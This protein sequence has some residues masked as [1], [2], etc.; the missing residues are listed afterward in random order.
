[1]I[2]KQKTTV[3]PKAK[4]KAKRQRP[5]RVGFDFD[6]VVIYNP[7]RILR[8]FASFIKKKNLVK[9]KELEFFIPEKNWEKFLWWLAHQSSLFPAK[10]WSQVKHLKQQGKIEPYLI[11]GR[12]TFLKS[13]LE[14]KFRLF[15]LDNIFNSVHITENNEQPHIFKERIIKEL[16]LDVFVE[17]NWDIVSY[18]NQ[19]HLPTKIIWVTNIVDS[20]KI[21]YPYK[22]KNLQEALESI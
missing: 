6:G 21:K 1:M 15:G 10:G 9:R 3:Q 7:A 19:C 18:L 17:D 4:K 12:N 13:D 20:Q 5:L 8:P 16:K 2:M 11:T 14:F 22:V